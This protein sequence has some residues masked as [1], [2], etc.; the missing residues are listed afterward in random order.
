MEDGNGSSQEL[1]TSTQGTN[2]KK[3]PTAVEATPK[4]ALN[5][6]DMVEIPWPVPTRPKSFASQLR[7]GPQEFPNSQG[8][9]GV[10]VAS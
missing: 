7:R 9:G 2:S 10:P 6:A 5:K 4:T 8:G 1:I 3:T